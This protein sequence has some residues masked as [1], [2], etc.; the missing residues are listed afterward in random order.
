MDSSLSPKDE[1]WFL[2]VYRHISNAVY[3]LWV[4]VFSLR[5][6]AYSVH[7]PYCHVACPALQY[8]SKLSHKRH[9]ILAIKL[10][11]IKCVFWFPLHSLSETFLII[12]R[13]RRNIT[14]NKRFRW[15]RGEC[16]GL[17]YPSSRGSNTVEAFEFFGQKKSSARLPSEGKVKPSVPCRKFTACKSTQ[18]WR[19]SRHFR[20]NSRQ[21]KSSNAV[22]DGIP[23][24]TAFEDLICT[25]AWWWPGSKVETCSLFM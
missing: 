3:I 17:W 25:W 6:Q 11:N 2:R 4:D 9:D 16:S 18:K 19:G 20:Q 8:F 10:L 21:I 22:L 15:S 24:S 1:V 14:I 12:R 23:S 13:I 7:A 5:Y